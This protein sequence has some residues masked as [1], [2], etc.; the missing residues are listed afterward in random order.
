LISSRLFLLPLLTLVLQLGST[1]AQAQMPFYTDDSAVTEMKKFHVEIFDEVDGLQSSQRPDLRQNTTNVKFNFSP[2][3][4]VEVD[5]DVPY[6]SINRTAGAANSNGVGDTNLG[7][8]WNLRE[9]TPDSGLPAFAASF[10]VEFPTGDVRQGLGSGLTDYWL[11]VIV[12]K[13]VSEA[14][15]INANLGLLFAGNS[16]TGAVGIQT[17]RGQVYTGGVSLLHDVT[18]RLTL[19]AEVYGGI[20]DGA[21]QDKTQLQTLLGAQF[22][23][24]EGMTLSFGILGGKYGATPQIGGQIGISIDFPDV[25]GALQH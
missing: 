19:G 22:A 3:N 25:R 16:S 21:G 23:V 4:H 12:Q 10:Y 11:N 7:V 6:L 24:R 18:P 13:P 8:K 9:A 15:R 5:L 1:A 17:R 2:F 20:S 14:T